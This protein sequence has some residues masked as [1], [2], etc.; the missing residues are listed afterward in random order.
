MPDEQFTL[1][2]AAVAQILGVHRDTVRKWADNGTLP[3]WRT[4]KTAAG[5]SERRFRR[6]D[7]EAMRAKLDAQP[8]PVRREVLS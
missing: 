3:C 6:S 8:G 4:P 5:Q 7:V 1:S 2:P